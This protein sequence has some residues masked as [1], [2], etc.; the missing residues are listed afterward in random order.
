MS[1]SGRSSQSSG[2]NDRGTC[3]VPA[4]EL[5]AN[6]ESAQAVGSGND[7]GTHVALHHLQRSIT[8]LRVDVR[9]RIRWHRDGKMA[10]VGVQ[11][12]VEDAL[13]GDLSGE[14]EPSGFQ[15]AQQAGQA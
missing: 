12:G 14:D 9:D 2:S 4:Y 6:P 7:L 15:L 13:L 8:E 5:L 11:R 3:T 10:D 1:K